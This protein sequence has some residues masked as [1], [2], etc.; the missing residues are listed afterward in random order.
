MIMMVLVLVRAGEDQ[1]QEMILTQQTILKVT[2][3]NTRRCCCA[4]A[5]L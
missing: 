3:F 2:Q 5:A 1:S 4:A